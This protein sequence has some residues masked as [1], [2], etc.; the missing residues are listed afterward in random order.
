MIRVALQM[1]TRDRA[2]YFGIILG[3]TLASFVIT[4]QGA[5]FI[6]IMSRTVATV[7]DMGDPEIWVMDPKVQYIEDIKPLQETALYRVRGVEGVGWASPLYKGLTRVR[8][9]DGTFQ[10]CN[11]IGLDDSTLTGGPPKM[12]EGSLRDLRLADAVIVDSIGASTRLARVG[13][14]GKPQPIGVGDVMEV[15]DHR[16][17]VVGV[18]DNT[19][20]FQSQPILY[21]TFS[22]ATTFI[23]KERKM[24]SFILVKAAPGTDIRALAD[25]IER[26]TSLAAYTH[27]E[28]VWRTVQY[29][30]ENTGIPINFGIAVA[31]GFV[32]G[33]VI[34]GFMFFSFTVDNLRY[35]GTL[36]AMGTPDSKLLAMVMTQALVVGL[37]GFGLGVGLAA[38]MGHSARNSPLAFR[39]P[40]QLVF[41]AGSATMVICMLSA[42]LSMRKVLALEPAAVFKG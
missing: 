14:D 30:V 4:Q 23:P 9:P 17:V 18:S 38:L 22:R 16:A 37:L 42:M 40:W 33:T 15:N 19:R 2:K 8:L 3:I 10:N 36:K 35:F 25:R 29:Y 26:N 34:T 13:P 1:L 31:L 41:V 21:T 20:T 7:T 39:M 24:L 12:K 11:I 27:D 28:F 6:G 32:V 5:I